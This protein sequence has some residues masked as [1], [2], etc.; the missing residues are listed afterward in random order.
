MSEEIVSVETGMVF[1]ACCQTHRKR[2]VKIEEG[3][4]KNE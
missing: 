1:L 3:G 4:V 2:V